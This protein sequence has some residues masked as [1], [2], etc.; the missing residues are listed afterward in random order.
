MIFARPVL[1]LHNPV[2]VSVHKKISLFNWFM[3]NKGPSTSHWEFSQVHSEGW[4][5]TDWHL[6]TE[7]S[8]VAEERPGT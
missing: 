3:R 7:S 1:G 5:G 8:L 6:A 2:Y 4:E